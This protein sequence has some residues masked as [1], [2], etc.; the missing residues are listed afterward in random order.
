M[1]HLHSS[2]TATSLCFPTNTNVGTNGVIST[3]PNNFGYVFDGKSF[4][5]HRKAAIEN[6]YQP[7]TVHLP[8]FAH[9]IDMVQDL[10]KVQLEA[11]NSC[12]AQFL[13]SSRILERISDVA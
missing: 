7:R 8:S 4:E 2:D 11:P 12:T 1:C 9:D 3:P 10:K 13:V 5:P 6:G